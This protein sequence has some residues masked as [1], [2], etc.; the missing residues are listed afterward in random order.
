MVDNSFVSRS[1][2]KSSSRTWYWASTLRKGNASLQRARSRGYIWKHELLLCMLPQACN[3]KQARKVPKAGDRYGSMS[4][5]Y[6]CFLRHV[7][8]HSERVR[9]RPASLSM[10]YGQ[11]C[12]SHS[13][14]LGVLP[15]RPFNGSNDLET[16]LTSE[17]IGLGHRADPLYLDKPTYSEKSVCMRPSVSWQ[18]CAST[19]HSVQPE[20]PR[21]RMSR[22][23]RHV[24]V[25][26]VV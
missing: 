1:C 3:K 12:L 18:P 22:G 8:H 26:H 5:H 16:C 13:R 9:E 23:S 6:V 24:D 17:S 11:E 19:T 25:P 21:V 15:L 10:D 14:S 20:Y 7:I 2:L 4:F